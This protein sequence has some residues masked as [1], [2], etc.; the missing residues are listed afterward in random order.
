[1][2]KVGPLI[3]V[4]SSSIPPLGL[5]LGIG[6]FCVSLHAGAHPIHGCSA[7]FEWP[8]LEPI[9]GAYETFRLSFALDMSPKWLGVHL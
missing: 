6:P 9:G 1:M 5:T 3:H 4:T 8:L 7:N 2:R